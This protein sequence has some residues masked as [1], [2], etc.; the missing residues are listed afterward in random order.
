MPF[1]RRG[2]EALEALV[3]VRL[4][5]AE[6][7]RLRDDAELAGLT[8]S[9]LVRRR[10]F[11]RPVMA[12]ADEAMVRE[13]RRVGGLLKHVHVTSGGAYSAETSAALTDVRKYIE[14][15]SARR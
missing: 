8:M 14:K 13:L 3:R 15:L 9:E 4:T 2:E 11:A 7:Q 12:S 1:E 10:T 6:K 5:E